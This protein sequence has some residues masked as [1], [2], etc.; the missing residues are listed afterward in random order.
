M[1][2]Q[3]Q[4]QIVVIQQPMG[5]PHLSNSPQHMSKLEFFMQKC[6]QRN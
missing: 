1:E 2:Q 6:H 5:V 3:G 4:P